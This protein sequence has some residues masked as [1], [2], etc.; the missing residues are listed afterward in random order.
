MNR[1]EFFKSGEARPEYWTV[2][3][4][5]KEAHDQCTKWFVN[6]VFFLRAKS[7][8]DNEDVQLI[9]NRYGKEYFWLITCIEVSQDVLFIQV[10]KEP[11]E[12][13]KSVDSIH[14]FVVNHG[15]S[16]QKITFMYDW[17]IDTESKIKSFISEYT[18][19]LYNIIIK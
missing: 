18:E 1:D 2:F 8:Y 10:D 12:E 11:Y 3:D 19:D 14:L 5:Q 16:Y 13:F 7:G 17:N 15:K 6:H 9:L 4:H